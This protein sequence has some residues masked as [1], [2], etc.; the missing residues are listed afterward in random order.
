MTQLLERAI[1]IARQLEAASQ[2][3]IARV[4]L[5]LVAADQEPEP[6]DAAN[7]GAVLEGLRQAERR[8][9]ASEAEIEAAFRCFD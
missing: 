5:H 9:F 2:D 4:M 6:I 8:E 3:K 1:E 7:L